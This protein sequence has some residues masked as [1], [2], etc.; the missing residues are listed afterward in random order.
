MINDVQLFY[1]I[2]SFNAWL[3]LSQFTD[4]NIDAVT[5]IATNAY[6]RDQIARFFQYLANS[7]KIFSK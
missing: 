1:L 3:L 6:Q 2:G 5:V 4:E 7:I